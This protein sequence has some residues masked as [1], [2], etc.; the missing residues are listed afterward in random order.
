MARV[1]RDRRYFS[2]VFMG[3]LVALLLLA[4]FFAMR[5]VNRDIRELQSREN[6]LRL[7]MTQMDMERTSLELELARVGSD[8]HVENEAREHYG[9]IRSGEIVFAFSDPDALKGYTEEECQIIMDE[10]RD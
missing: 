8:G 5:W 6:A 3:I 7:S 2:W 1:D 4:F 9:F 10:M